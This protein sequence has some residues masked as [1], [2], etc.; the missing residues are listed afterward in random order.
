MC[1]PEMERHETT[2]MC[3]S[4][5]ERLRYETTCMCIPEMERHEI[6]CMC[7]S[8]MERLRYETACMCISEM[9]MLRQLYAAMLRLKSCVNQSRYHTQ[10]Q[11]TDTGPCLVRGRRGGGGNL[12]Y[13]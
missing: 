3:I 10:S 12:Q 11:Y 1:I 4:E 9:G 6:T 8:G 7:L 2:G 5:V 13:V